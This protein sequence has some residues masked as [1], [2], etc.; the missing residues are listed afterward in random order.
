MTLYTLSRRRRTN[1]HHSSSDTCQM[2]R[3]E[4]NLQVL[5]SNSDSSS[6]KQSTKIGKFPWRLIIKIPIKIQ[7]ASYALSLFLAC[8]PCVCVSV[9]AVCW[10]Q[11]SELISQTNANAMQITKNGKQKGI[12]NVFFLFYEQINTA[13]FEAHVG[14]L[15]MCQHICVCVCVLYT[16]ININIAS[17]PRRSKSI[18]HNNKPNKTSRLWE[19]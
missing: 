14:K 2:K 5:V 6:N 3:N 8:L 7:L 1:G 9:S 13:T 15:G 17:A 18:F 16:Y 10:H 4:T 12:L 11:R 19:K